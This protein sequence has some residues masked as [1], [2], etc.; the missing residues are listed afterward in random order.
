VREKEWRREA[1]RVAR[2]ICWINGIVTIDDV[3]SAMVGYVDRT[4]PEDSD[5]VF[6]RGFERVGV[7]STRWPEGTARLIGVWK[8]KG[9]AWNYTHIQRY[10][11]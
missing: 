8:L 2:L 3:L 1:R 4:L 5:A 9:G 7:R 6:K 10:L 11:I